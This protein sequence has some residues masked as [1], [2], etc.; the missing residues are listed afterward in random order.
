M[1]YSDLRAFLSTLEE[2]GQLL[3]YSETVAPEPDLGAAARAVSNLTDRGPALLFD[4]IEGYE[5]GKVALNVVGSWPNHALMLGLPKDTPVKEQFFEFSKR[6]KD[7][8]V[9][10]E[11]RDDPPWQE[12]VLETGIDL[13]H[14]LPLFRLNRWDVGCYIDKAVVVSCDPD[15]PQN[16][17]KQNVGIYRIQVKDVDTLGIQPL[18]TH[19]IGLHL[20]RA[21]ERGENLPVT[22]AIS[23]EPAISTVGGMPLAYDQSEYE[24]AGALQGSPYRIAQTSLT[25][26][27]VPWGSEVVLEGEILAGEREIEGPF[28][29]FTGHYSGGRKQPVI[30]VHKVSHRPGPIFEHLYLGMPWTE[31]DYTLALNTSVPLHQ[32][33]KAEF[34]EVQAVNAMYTQGLLAVVSVKQRYG[35]FAKAVGMRAMTTPHG[36]GYCKVVIVV[37]ETVDPFNLAQVMWALSVKFHPR[38]DIVTVPNASVLPL[39]PSSEPAGITDK[40][41]LDATTP[42]APETRGHYSQTVDEPDGTRK[43][44]DIIKE[45]L[46]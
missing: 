11:R 39:D 38:H 17:D 9:E 24:M 7:Y 45:L 41:V 42:I 34:P 1:A 8:P 32:Q 5:H 19:D 29:E 33:L 12:H 10:V 4:D 22:I 15:E 27:D 6:W 14:L 25:G 35:G 2:N 3:R 36:L 43:W 16:F 40:V 37:D 30:K 26:M 46:Q 23:N 21:E 20:R 13:F 18:P 28:G 31:M 44:E